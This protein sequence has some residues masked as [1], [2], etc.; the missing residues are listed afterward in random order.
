MTSF[1]CVDFDYSN[2]SLE[3]GFD[4]YCTNQEG[5]RTTLSGGYHCRGVTTTGPHWTGVWVA[6]GGAGNSGKHIIKAASGPARRLV[7]D[8]V[9]N[10]WVK[11]Y[12]ITVAQATTLYQTPLRYKH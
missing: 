12:G 7:R 2:T 1:T 9:I 5:V 6:T 11:D 4:L 3:E 10:G 8:Y